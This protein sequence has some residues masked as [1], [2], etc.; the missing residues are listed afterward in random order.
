M[1][2]RKTSLPDTV[3][4]NDAIPIN[5]PIPPESIPYTAISSIT[6]YSLSLSSFYS[7]E[8]HN[9]LII[10]LLCLLLIN[11]FILLFQLMLLMK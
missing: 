3:L 9:Y 5:Y 6:L 4:F 7:L 1:K 11:Q 8:I 10:S 2:R